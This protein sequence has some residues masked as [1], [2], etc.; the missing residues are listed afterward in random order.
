VDDNIQIK[1]D[2]V[3]AMKSHKCRKMS[4]KHNNMKIMMMTI[5]LSYLKLDLD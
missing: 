3:D 5:H 4:T 1:V 2:K